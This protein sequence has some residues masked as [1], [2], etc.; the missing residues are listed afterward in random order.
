MP[1]RAPSGNP[2]DRSPTRPP[3]WSADVPWPP[4]DGAAHWQRMRRRF[5]ITAAIGL[6]LLLLFAIAMGTLLFWLVAV[7][8]NWIDPARIAFPPLSAPVP[9]FAPPNPRWPR[10][11]VPFFCFGPLLLLG[12]FWL[13]RSFR[14]FTRPLGN[15]I[16]AVGRVEGGDYAVR[17]EARGPRPMRA[18]IKSFNGMVTRLQTNE[19]QRRAM[20][21]DVT[22]ELRTPITVIQGNLEGMLDGI[23]PPDEAHLQTILDE[24]HVLARLIDDLRTLAQAESGMLKLQHEPVDLGVVIAEVLASFSPTADRAKVTLQRELQGQLPSIEADPIRVREVLVNLLGNALR[25]TPAGGSITITATQENSPARISITVSDTG[26]GI[27]P[28]LLPHVFDRFA[29]SRDSMGS[30]LGLAIARQLVDAHG[31]EISAASTLGQGTTIR[32]SL[33]LQVAV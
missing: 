1:H 12:G 25:Y 2:G 31:G 9:P 5:V 13:V 16:E 26:R 21:A 14:R 18:F 28:E 19:E 23:Y 24:T 10:F 27:A 29:K 7:E 32:F 30:G 3:W 20:L 4:E 11:N 22:H 17:V 33:P 15:L 6:V 8:F